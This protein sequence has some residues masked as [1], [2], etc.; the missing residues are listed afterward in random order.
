M[1]AFSE[2]P[3]QST[4]VSVVL[5]SLDP[6]SRLLA[7]VDGLLALGFSEIIIVNDGSGEKSL[8]YFEALR[9]YPQ[10]RILTHPKNLGKGAA[11]RT[12]FS[13]FLQHS[14]QRPGVVT[15]D[16]DGQHLPKDIL[17]CCEAMIHQPDHVILGCRD[18]SAAGVPIKSLMGNQITSFV[19]RVGC[20]IRLPDTQ[21]GLRAIPASFLPF[22]L[23]VPGDRFDYET[24]MLL[25]M[26]QGGI[27]FQ[28]VSIET[29]YDGDNHTTH[30]HAIRD[31]FQIYRRI[32]KFMLSSG[33]ASFID[34]GAFFLL[35]AGSNLLWNRYS[36]LLCT[37]IARAISSFVNFNA[38]RKLV[39]QC[40]NSYTRTMARYY[41]LCVPQTLVSAGSVWLISRLLSHQAPWAVTLLKIVVDSI[42]FF[43]SFR[44]Q[45]DWVFQKASG[46]PKGK[47]RLTEGR[48]QS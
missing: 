25:E 41:T 11:L 31:S 38:N 34:E 23:S 7:V 13:W 20:G 43:M 44:I 6:D 47:E 37:V 32:L 35:A 12:A 29:V 9:K 21:T 48:P 42:L 46:S 10:C 4:D 26:K 19:F 5:P 14:G 15:V 27:P 8:P 17:A 28:T 39:F 45:R 24:N 16:G 3:Y 2:K 18:F 40:G 36:I 33:V 22:M 30:F 1:A